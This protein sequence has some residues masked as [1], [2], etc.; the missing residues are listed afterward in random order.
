MAIDTRIQ[1]KE[2]LER[3]LSDPAVLADPERVKELSIEFSRIEKD[4]Q[5]AAHTFPHKGLF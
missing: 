3:L 2:E 1:R 5:R 4:L